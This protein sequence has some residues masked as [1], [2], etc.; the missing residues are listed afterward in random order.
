[1]A[2]VEE[3]FPNLIQLLGAYFHQDWCDDDPDAQAV[4]R[5][6]LNDAVPGQVQDVVNE[7]EELLGKQLNDDQLKQ[8]LFV[9]L[10]CYYDP[11]PDHI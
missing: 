11:T 10:G 4:L 6:Y 9:D 7:I 1:M 8:M 2:S 3:Q 5:R